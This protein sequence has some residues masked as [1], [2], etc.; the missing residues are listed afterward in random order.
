MPRKKFP[1][2]PAFLPAPGPFSSAHVTR[3]FLDSFCMP[4]F[5]SSA[6]EATKRSAV[7][8]E[9]KAVDT[10]ANDLASLQAI[11]RKTSTPWSPSAT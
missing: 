3:P 8:R 7:R 5:Y 6:A 4:D 1:A 11:A 2:T 9:I 10:K